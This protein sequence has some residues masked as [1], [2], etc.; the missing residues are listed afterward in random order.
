MVV[1]QHSPCISDLNAALEGA[2]VWTM[3]V[4]NVPR[5]P[6][7]RISRTTNNKRGR[8]TNVDVR[9]RARAFLV[10]GLML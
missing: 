2:S 10:L 4:R 6:L 8:P 9:G 7:L 3:E 1:V 5:L